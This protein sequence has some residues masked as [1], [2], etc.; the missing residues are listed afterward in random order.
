[1]VNFEISG[2]HNLIIL[3]IDGK[4][5]IRVSSGSMNFHNA[6]DL[7]CCAVSACIGNNLKRICM[8]EELNPKIFQT[9]N[10]RLENSIIKITISCPPDLKDE[11]K[12]L[13]KRDLYG[14]SV[15]KLLVDPVEISFID[16]DI[17]TEKLLEDKPKGCCGG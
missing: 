15:S 11:T 9:I 12:D 7:L 5:P 17:P 1:M 14:C 13:I 16:N 2:T 6:N 10:V 4:S 8:W 3:N